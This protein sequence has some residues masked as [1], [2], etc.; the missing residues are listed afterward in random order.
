MPLPRPRSRHLLFGLALAALA[1]G[2][3]GPP[4]Q[5]DPRAPIAGDIGRYQVLLPPP[6]A[7]EGPFPV[8]YF[9]HDYLGHSGVL[10]RE[11]VAVEL[12]RRMAEGHMQPFVLVAPEGG[13]GLWS[14]SYD[15]SRR[16]QE[17]LA[18]GLR[19][20][21]ESRFP[22]HASRSNRAVVGI[23]MGGFGA[24]NLAL[25]EPGLY[26]AAASLSGMVVPLRWELLQK[27]HWISRLAARRVFGSSREANNMHRHDV[28]RRLPEV[29]ALPQRERP[30]LLLRCGTE[31][32]YQLAG[33][34]RL[35]AQVAGDAGVE[36]ELVL[37]PGTHDWDYWRSSA[38]AVVAWTVQRLG[39]DEVTP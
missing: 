7:G 33:A 5:R 25:S 15:G 29:A 22:V 18:E 13:R 17:W 4:V 8:V 37:E 24:L 3:S 10:W 12:E 27:S 9:L 38:V 32:K 31:D 16:Y 34:A 1:C 26:R 20:Q 39:A 35:F 19:R 2:S 30:H 6:E 28:F 14:D 23:S 21:V 36:V 11:G